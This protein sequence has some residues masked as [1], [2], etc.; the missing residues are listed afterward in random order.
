MPPAPPD[1][2]IVAAIVRG[3]PYPVEKV[4]GRSASLSVSEHGHFADAAEWAHAL[5]AGVSRSIRLRMRELQPRVPK[6]AV[7]TGDKYST[8]RG[9]RTSS[10]HAYLTGWPAHL[11]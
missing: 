1:P 6:A 2:D 9:E 3:C 11:R 8:R 10:H 4:T 7:G 5:H